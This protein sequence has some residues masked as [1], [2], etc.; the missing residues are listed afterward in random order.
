M[1]A[2]P[3]LDPVIRLGKQKIA[4]RRARYLPLAFP[5]AYASSAEGY[6]TFRT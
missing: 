3:Y 4:R 2:C 5:R 1:G 6:N